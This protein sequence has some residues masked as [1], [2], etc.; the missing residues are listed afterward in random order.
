MRDPLLKD[1]QTIERFIKNRKKKALKAFEAGQIN[2]LDILKEMLAAGI[3]RLYLD[4][5]HNR[6]VLSKFA[7]KALSKKE[8]KMSQLYKHG[9]EPYTRIANCENLVNNL[10]NDEDFK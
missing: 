8:M 5:C 3:R 4:A 2:T 6:R 1:Q 7:T 10:K 9:E